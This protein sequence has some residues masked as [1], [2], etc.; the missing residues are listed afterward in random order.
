MRRP[1]VAQ[2]S[3]LE[4]GRYLRA[5]W[6]YPLGGCPGEGGRKRLEW[7]GIHLFYFPLVNVNRNATVGSR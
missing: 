7:K 5:S 2:E 1:R 3:R 4:S 6:G